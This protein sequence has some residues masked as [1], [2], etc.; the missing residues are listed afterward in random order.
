MIYE[1]K[2]LGASAVLLICAIL[3]DGQLREYLRLAHRL[4][5]S[6]LVEV[7]TAEEAE[8]ALAAGARIIGVNNRDLK[9]FQVDV[10]TSI[11][12]RKQIPEER[13]YV[14]ESGI[15]TPQDIAKLYENGTNGVL[16]GETL[17]RAKDKKAMLDELRGDQ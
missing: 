5:L 6:A 1:A 7:H 12:L 4:G 13:L 3:S 10:D 16:I 15:R 8:R 14:S 11:R 9:T 2:L 17:M